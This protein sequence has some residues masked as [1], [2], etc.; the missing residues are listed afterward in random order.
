VLEGWG[1]KRG[2]LTGGMSM[3]CRFIIEKLI[4][5]LKGGNHNLGKNGENRRGPLR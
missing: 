1:E 3:D 4:S 2:D 5:L